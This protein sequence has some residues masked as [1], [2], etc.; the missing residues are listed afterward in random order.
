MSE[1]EVA[2]S[3][4][5][6]KPSVVFEQGR[7]YMVCASSGHGKTSLLNFIYGV[8]DSFD[9]NV[10]LTEDE[11][12]RV[13]HTPPQF[14]H[15]QISSTRSTGAC[16]PSQEGRTTQD[17]GRRTENAACSRG[18]FCRSTENELRTRVL[19]FMFQDLALFP[20]LTAKENVLLKNRLTNFKSDAEIEAMLDSLLPPEKKNQP[21]ATLSL[22]QRQ[23]VAA[24]RALCQPFKFILM[25]EP[26]SHIDSENARRLATMVLDEVKRQG[27]GL[28]VT[29]LDEIDY[30]PFDEILNL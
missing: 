26:F 3:D 15:A 5:Y 8:S 20:E 21:V 2:G 9:G 4:I 17:G 1:L 29:A 23:R 11:E 6:L 12:R 7:F 18:A 30:F 10:Y 25:D 19:S 22:G 13:R 24:V 28:I 27:A 16:T 14:C